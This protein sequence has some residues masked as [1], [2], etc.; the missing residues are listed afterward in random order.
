VAALALTDEVNEA[1]VERYGPKLPPEGSLLGIVTL[2]ATGIH[3]PIF[4]RIRV[5]PGGAYRRV[6]VTQGFSAAFVADDTLAFARRVMAAHGAALRPG[7][8]AKSLRLVKRAL[9]L[10]GLPGEP[11]LR[12]GVR[13]GIYFGAASAEVIDM[14]RTGTYRPLVRPSVS[15]VRALWVKEVIRRQQVREV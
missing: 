2:C 5:R 15:E 12:T 10:S 6:G 7:L 1:Y 13:K 11:L 3:C 4:N 9:E 14:L 8:F